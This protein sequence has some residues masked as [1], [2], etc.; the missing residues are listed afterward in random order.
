MEGIFIKGRKKMEHSRWVLIIRGL[1]WKRELRFFLGIA[2]S[3]SDVS[4]TR[5]P[6]Q[7]WGSYHCPIISNKFAG[8]DDFP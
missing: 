7:G 1:D 5:D 4:F 2:G 3:V 6:N 8:Y